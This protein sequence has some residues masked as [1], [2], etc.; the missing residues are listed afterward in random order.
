MAMAR[1]NSESVYST[2]DDRMLLQDGQCLYWNQQE[3]YLISYVYIIIDSNNSEAI[4]IVS[5]YTKSERRGLREPVGVVQ[6]Y[7]NQAELK[8]LLAR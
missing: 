8:L 7:Q 4:S 3:Y 5:S 2:T 6:I 1:P